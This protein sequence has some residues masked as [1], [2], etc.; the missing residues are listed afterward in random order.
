MEKVE[1]LSVGENKQAKICKFFLKNGTCK[2]GDNCHFIHDKNICKHHYFYN[3]CKHGNKC[4]FLHDYQD[5]SNQNK[6]YKNKDNNKDNKDNKNNKRKHPKNTE[7]FNP[8]HSAPDMNILV[9]NLGDVEFYKNIY[10]PNDIIIVQGLLKNDDY[11]G[12]LLK[13]IKESGVEESELWK[14][15]H[16]DTHL[17]ADDNKNWK[18]KVPT[19]SYIV[20]QITKYF[21]MSSTS[22][23]LNWYKDTNDWKPF[24]HDAAA[25]K[26]H[27]AEK[28]N[29]TVGI[30]FGHTRNVAFQ[31]AKTKTV[32]S[33]PLQDGSAYAFSR[34]VNVN[35]KHG[36]PQ[37]P[38]AEFKEEGRISIIVWGMVEIKE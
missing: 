21:N 1:E 34:D 16:G 12:K 13:E 15:W 23:R 35:W 27:I 22:T 24:H 31:H 32:V 11:Y 17:I 14:L 6:E 8:D 26:P 37:I 5:L 38:P 2:H 3:D 25:V 4:K 9:G 36:I 18:E 7:N 28:Q 29:F 33:V 20:E 10:S 30:S 19:F